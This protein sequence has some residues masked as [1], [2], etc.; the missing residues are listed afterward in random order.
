MNTLKKYKTLIILSLLEFLFY[1]KLNVYDNKLY[2]STWF[3]IGI[4]FALYNIFNVIKS[5]PIISLFMIKSNQN[6]TNNVKIH[7]TISE[8]LFN[9]ETMT[10]LIFISFNFLLYIFS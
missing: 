7:S 9:S 1:F 10:I 3:F 8:R 5:N 4:T 2:F 6:E